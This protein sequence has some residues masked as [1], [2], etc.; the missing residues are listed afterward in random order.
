LWSRLSFSLH[1]IAENQSKTKNQKFLMY[2]EKKMLYPPLILLNR[3]LKK[4]NKKSKGVIFCGYYIFHFQFLMPYH[5]K[6]WRWPNAKNLTHPN[7][8]RFKHFVISPSFRTTRQTKK[9]RKSQQQKMCS[10]SRSV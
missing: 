8:L 3:F 2:F 4:K 9:V 5:E 7:L 10:S 1:N 6:K